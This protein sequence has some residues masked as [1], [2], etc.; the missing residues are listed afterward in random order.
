MV[1]GEVVCCKTNCNNPIG[2]APHAQ[3][4]VLCSR[5]WKR[6]PDDFSTVIKRIKREEENKKEQ[7]KGVAK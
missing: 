6:G 3:Y 1:I 4:S 7:N 5:L 2:P